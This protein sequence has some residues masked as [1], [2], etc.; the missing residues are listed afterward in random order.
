MFEVEFCSDCVVS[1]VENRPVGVNVVGVVVVVI[2]IVVVDWV[3]NLMTYQVPWMCRSAVVVRE[4]VM[5]VEIESGA[6]VVQ[7]LVETGMHASPLMTRKMKMMMTKMVLFLERLGD[8]KML[9]SLRLLVR[10]LTE[11]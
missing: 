7:A 3:R 2:V 6:V 1:H 11:S 4:V 10:H 5:V 8:P 9:E